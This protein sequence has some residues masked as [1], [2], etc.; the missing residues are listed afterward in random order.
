MVAVK[1]RT[2]LE[3]RIKSLRAMGLMAGVLLASSAVARGDGLF[4]KTNIT[5]SVMTGTV[6]QVLRRC[7]SYYLDTASNLYLSQNAADSGTPVV[8][9][10]NWNNTGS[11]RPEKVCHT[12]DGTHSST[13]IDWDVTLNINL[14]N[15]PVGTWTKAYLTWPINL[16]RDSTNA[17]NTVD[18]GK[19]LNLGQSQTVMQSFYVPRWPTWDEFCA[20]NPGD[21][22][23]AG[24]P[25]AQ[26]WVEGQNYEIHPRSVN[27]DPKRA[28]RGDPINTINGNMSLAETDVIIS[29]PGLPLQFTRYYNSMVDCNGT[30]G[31]RWGHNYDL[32]LTSTNTVFSGVTNTW[33]TL[34]TGDGELYWF[35]QLT[36]GLFQSPFDNA[37]VLNQTNGAYSVSIPPSTTLLLDS[38]GVPTLV[39]NAWG[40]AISFSY[41]NAFP[42]NLLVRVQH[43]DG[44]ALNFAYTSNLLASVSTP[45]NSLSL[46]FLYDGNGLL[47][48]SVNSNSW[49]RQVTAYTYD[50]QGTGANCILTQRVNALGDVFVWQYAT[51][52]T[53]HATG[54]AIRSFIGT[55]LLDTQFG[56]STNIQ[57]QTQVTYSRDTTNQVYQYNYHPVLQ[58]ILEIQG[59]VVAITNWA[60][61]GVGQKFQYDDFGNATN[62]TIY[63][64][65]CGQWTTLAQAFDARHN[66]TN[67]SYGFCSVSNPP[68][69][70]SWHSL[71]RTLTAVVDPEGHR[72]E[73]DYTNGLVS[74]ERI[75]PVSNQPAATVYTYTSNGVLAAVTNANGNWTCF[76]N[77]SYGCPTQTISAS[78]ATNWIAWDKL[79][80]ITSIT[81]PGSTSDTNDPPN[82]IPRVIT[83]DHN[84]LGWVR[85]ITYPDS[86]VESFAFDA[87]GNLT[88]HVDAGGRTNCFAWLPTR[89]PSSSSRFLTAG[90]SNQEAKISMSYNQQMNTLNIKDELGRSVEGYQLDL[91]D[92]PQSV[93]NVEGQV[94]SLSWGLGTLLKCMV[95]FDGTTNGF[96]YDAGSRLSQNITSDDTISLTYFNN[97]LPRTFG[98]SRG[99]I[100][101]AYDGANRLI[102]QTQ[103]VPSGSLFYGYYPA[104][105]L[106]NVISVAGTN[107]Y[108]LDSGDR[109]Q[110]LA[111]ASPRGRDSVAYAYDPVSGMLSGASYSNGL[112]CSYSYDLMNR[113]NAMIWTNVYNQVVKSRKYAYTAAGLISNITFE[114]GEK[115]NYSYDSLDRLTRERHTDY[116]GQV[117]SDN[118]YEYDLAGN[119]TRKSVLDKDGNTLVTVNYSL[120][121]GNKIGSWTVSET[122]LATSFSVAGYSADPIG[123]GIRYGKLW[124][125]NSPS[126]YSIPYVANNTNFYA[127]DL[128]CGMGTQYVYAAIRD[129]AGNTTYVTNRFY[130]T[131]LTN[132]TYQYSSAGCLTNRQN[133]GKDYVDSL[134][135]VWNGQYQLTAVTTNGNLAET[136]AYDGTGRRSFIAAGGTTNW[137]V[138]DG[139][140]VVAEV[141]GT[142][143][144]KKSYVYGSGIDNP[145][146][147]T[148]YAATTNT[149]YFI[150]DHLGSTLAL[151][152]ALGNIVE[153]Y[154][155]DAWGRVLGVYNSAGT[156]IDESALGNRILWMGREYSSRSGLYYF[157]ARWYDPTIG[158]WISSDPIG[159]SGGLNQYV[160]CAN[161]PV[162]MKDPLGLWAWDHDWIQMGAGGLFGFYGR[163]AAS[164]WM[165]TEQGAYATLDGL[166]P[167]GD[168]FSGKYDGCDESLQLS[169]SFGKLSQGLLLSAIP[170]RPFTSTLQQVTHWGPPLQ[171]G[172]WVMTGGPSIRNWIMSG[173]KY[174]YWQHEV[175]VIVDKALQYPSGWQFIKGYLG[176]RLFMF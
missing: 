4:N 86:S 91:Q 90:G 100:T 109:L 101:N 66:V 96:A 16:Y 47:T 157:R 15:Y 113:L 131:C 31:R 145:I 21:S 123:V 107:T 55:N 85:K 119:R 128:I 110:K 106:S 120:P 18:C 92:R 25:A 29:C 28:V 71:Y 160:F 74:V 72:S 3:I 44:Q 64:N 151:T 114:T 161:N 56:F 61:T 75:F 2:P 167:F 1:K 170:F 5:S 154:R 115:A 19:P 70:L 141:D 165:K 20:G 41:T 37:W 67:V 23:G 103:P 34:H 152:D 38:N 136:Y 89:K 148:V 127:F 102:T 98:N 108:T 9:D 168:P 82:M 27:P 146:S 88:N 6:H 14:A 76:Q 139:I 48:N 94:M 54:Q 7:I 95:R 52:A 62:T 117:I 137:M 99:T 124:V 144:L 39:S 79:G 24:S 69:S 116:Y 130:P 155:Y 138:Y 12:G 46:Q 164:S 104:G 147:M 36:N 171:P 111:V 162:N 10:K 153:S 156:Q 163:D 159:I 133:S 105:Q 68:S 60:G 166:I 84:E 22:W 142:G 158:K 33:K 40:N 93:T 65:N 13:R 135:L 97:N 129:V 63:D 169:K 59:P 80:N 125:S 118:K 49:G 83:F 176:Q 87:L 11:D 150:K 73:W 26:V 78:G 53:G 172:S 149:Y 174:P 45:T 43:S 77:D 57:N 42:S 51:N 81:L 32:R 50:S 122:N 112:H 30:L 8:S 126:A 173:A 175:T 58:R 35:L 17:Y 132:G 121:T 134:G 143:N 140:Q